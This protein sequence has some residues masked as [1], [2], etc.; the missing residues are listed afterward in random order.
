MYERLTD[1]ARTV[2][3]LAYQAAHELRQE[4]FG[5]EHILLGL[6]REGEGLAANV[7]RHVGEGVSE[8]KVLAAIQP[9]PLAGVVNRPVATPAA[10]RIVE[11]AL[12]EAHQLGHKYV[13]TEHLLLGLLQE[14][15]GVTADLL[16][17]VAPLEHF[18]KEIHDI[19]GTVIDET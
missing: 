15:E 6:I 2:L 12:A 18:R 16:S 7:L 19:P 5:S 9:G 3:R 11:A 13:G 14:K 10:K 4:G 8:Q 17:E 1:R